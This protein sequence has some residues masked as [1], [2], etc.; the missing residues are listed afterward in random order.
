MALAALAGTTLLL[1]ACGGQSDGA[2][3]PTVPSVAPPADQGGSSQG[4]SNQGGSNQG[5]SNQGGSDQGDPEA[6]TD[7]DEAAALYMACMQEAGF[8]MAVD[9]QVDGEDEAFVAADKDCQKHLANAEDP[10]EIDPEAL[11]EQKDFVLE[12]AK[13]M[14]AAGFDVEV[15]ADG[16]IMASI[17]DSSKAGY[18]EANTKCSEG[19]GDDSIGDGPIS[20]GG[21]PQDGQP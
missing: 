13:C 6:P 3:S 19:N 4:G 11:A 17:E 14:Q 10:F 18:D 21:E 7:M 12:Y 5:G 1:T 8:S 20:V 16:G 15:G 2:S 9:E